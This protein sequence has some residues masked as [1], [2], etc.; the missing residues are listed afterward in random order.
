MPLESNLTVFGGEG[1]ISVPPL[2][3]ADMIVDG[4]RITLNADGTFVGDGEAFIQAVASA[5]NTYADPYLRVVLWMLCNSIRA[6][7]KSA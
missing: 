7:M 6:K 2:F 5:R 1:T 4:V 3:P